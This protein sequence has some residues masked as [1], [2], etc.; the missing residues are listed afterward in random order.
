MCLEF[1]LKI[2]SPIK[3]NLDQSLY[4]LNNFQ[5]ESIKR[6]RDKVKILNLF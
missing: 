1:T 3:I 4:E 2:S 5:N 6:G